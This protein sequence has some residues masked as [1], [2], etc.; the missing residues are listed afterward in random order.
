M[1]ISALDG[2]RPLL[3]HLLDEDRDL[4]ATALGELTR[5]LAA[6]PSLWRPL[7]R[8][9]QEH[10]WYERLLLTPRVEI[11]LIGWAPGQGTR[12]H[13]HGDAQGALT[14][15]EGTLTEDVYLGVT[16]RDRHVCP[17]GTWERVSGSTA[18]F[19]F[20]H[21]HRVRNLSAVNATSIHAYSPPGRQMRYF[22]TPVAEAA[23]AP[24]LGIDEMLRRARRELV[25]LSA[26]EVQRAVAAGALLVDIRPQTRRE[27][28]GGTIPGA[29]A[30]DRNLLEWRLDPLSP[31]RL[32]EVRGHDQQVVVFCSEG[33]TSSLAA[34]SLQDLG[35]RRATDLEG[36]FAAWAAAGLPVE[37]A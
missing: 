16:L 25:R 6:R 10:R 23:P 8:H 34:A 20:D 1:S 13:G 30:I 33:Y 19:A 15:I 4:D 11:W 18:T 28:D 35:L 12:P 37:R 14:V 32:P 9:D 29:L 3:A 31:W 22:G 5:G 36:G 27:A 2:E 17:S 21:V 24:V 7:L 26:T